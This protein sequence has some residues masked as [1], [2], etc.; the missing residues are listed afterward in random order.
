MQHSFRKLRN[1][2]FLAFLMVAFW[3]VPMAAAQTD[4]PQLT[5]EEYIERGL[6]FVEQGELKLAAADFQA[7][8]ELDPENIDALNNLGLVYIELSLY[9]PASELFE[10]VLASDPG[11]VVANGGMCAALAFIQPVQGEARCREVIQENPQN[12]EAINSLGIAL[13]LQDKNEDAI[14]AFQTAIELNP[15]HKWA[16][17]NLGRAYLNSGDYEQAISEL[18]TAITVYPQNKTAHY[19]LGLAYAQQG[20]FATSIPYY[21]QA[22]KLDPNLAGAYSDLGIIYQELGQTEKAVSALFRY[23]QLV[24]EDPNRAEI[25][26]MLVKMG[27]PVPNVFVQAKVAFVSER[28][29]NMEIYSMN[30]DGSQLTRLTDNAGYDV[31]PAYSPDGT[32]ILF[33]SDRNGNFDIYRMKADGT[34]VIQLTDDSGFD[35]TP[36]WSDD[37]NF[38]T[39]VSDRSGK[40][41]IYTMNADGSEQTAV[42]VDES[43]TIYAPTWSH[44]AES[45]SL[46]FITDAQGAFDLYVIYGVTNESGKLTED[47][48]DVLTPD[49]SVNGRF[50]VFAANPFESYDLFII[51]PDGTDLTRITDSEVGEYRPRW[52]S[53]SNYI[54]Y[55]VG[56]DEMSEIEIINESGDVMRLT[57]NDAFDGMPTWGPMDQ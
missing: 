30:T 25:E 44:D 45:Q 36:V 52:S 43:F 54:I 48:G 7:A 6:D 14:A 20:D 49:W 57:Q 24:P 22:I 2:V 18:T 29:G 10:T 39:F 35:S 17:N 41:G 23:L 33:A 47:F 56:L 27:G 31:E 46:A 50:I 42:L 32:Q 26:A 12:A 37:S 5:S 40:P 16:H 55:S 21:E 34:D 9:E 11:N 13:I 28:D 3:D 4:E 19:N 1:L 8:L 38:I 51:R 53:D 15:Q